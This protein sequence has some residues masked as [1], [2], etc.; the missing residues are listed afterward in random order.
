MSHKHSRHSCSKHKVLTT[1]V[2]S[3]VPPLGAL[4]DPV[5]NGSLTL[6]Q[7]DGL[8]IPPRELKL[9]PGLTYTVPQAGLFYIETNGPISR[10]S[11]GDRASVSITL[12]RNFNE[13]LSRRAAFDSPGS[14]LPTAAWSFGI[15]QSLNQGDRIYV[16]AENSGPATVN[17]GS[18]FGTLRSVLNI[19][20]LS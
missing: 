7:T 14:F 13:V 12:F 4:P 11:G 17:L 10:V 18:N 3:S 19:I 2:S 9:I 15:V 8:V 6:L 5:A 20:Q 16:T 1:S